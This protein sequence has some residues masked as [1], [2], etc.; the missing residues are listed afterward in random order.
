MIQSPNLHE[1]HDRKTFQQ[2]FEDQVNRTPD[3]T[4]IH[5]SGTQFSYRDLNAYSNRLAHQLQERGVRAETVV[6]IYLP[7][8][9]ELVVSILGVLKAGGAF[10][11]LDPTY[12]THRTNQTLTDADPSILITFSAIRRASSSRQVI[13]LDLEWPTL[14]SGDDRNLSA[15]GDDDNLAYIIYTSGVTGN[16]KG[17]LLTHRGLCHYKSALAVLGITPSDVYLCTASV[18]FSSSV[19]QLL[20]PLCF[21]A[22]VVIAT[23]EQLADPIKLFNLIKELNVTIID[24]V[25]SYWRMCTRLI[26]RLPTD[27]RANLLQN[28]L[29]L[30]VSASEPL[31]F[32]LPRTWRHEFKHFAEFVNG[33]G[34]TET[35][36]LVTLHKI[37]DESLAAD[38]DIPIGQPIGNTEFDV[39]DENGEEVSVGGTGELYVRGPSLARGYLN[40]TDLDAQAFV[41]DP[42]GLSE[43]RM[44]RTG[45]I[46]RRLSDF[47]L[48]FV[49]RRDDQV[50]VHGVRVEI[51][52]IESVLHE[53]PMVDETAVVFRDDDP[54]N[55]HLLAYIVSSE[56]NSNILG[57][58][59]A[60][61]SSRLPQVM[62]PN[63]FR[64]VQSLPRTE[65]GKVDRAQLKVFSR[66]PPECS[67]NNSSSTLGTLEL[68]IAADWSR[69]L[70]TEKVDVNANF[71][72]LGGDSLMAMELIAMLQEKFPTEVPM[73]ALFFEDP[74]V[75]GMARAIQET[76]I[77]G[78]G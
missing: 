34:H 74:T 12:P 76:S 6:G 63:E 19:R 21:G 71:F 1:S 3:A 67:A 60:F 52:E 37:P 33:Y 66:L 64:I 17:T 68:T 78:E 62:I 77:Q 29:R 41:R 44:Y 20:I 30:I 51:G 56:T 46:V 16:P 48:A 70:K 22:A 7:R 59:R 69:L 53:H 65:N 36:G 57:E 75:A 2:L 42:R 4:A 61:L 18:A 55:R 14:L 58:L 5:A 49:G 9:I 13:E 54:E 73:L 10:L 47:S 11:A 26:G 25:P 32:D 40:R 28:R 39:L 8:S 23:V 27:K 72:E 15:V 35:T 43:E 38:Y 45:D 31:S 24:L 50:K